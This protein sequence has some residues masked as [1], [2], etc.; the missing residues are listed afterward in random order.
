MLQFHCFTFNAFSEN[1]Y[2]V[3][4]E[5]KKA[6]LI[7][8]GC[9]DKDEQKTLVDYVEKK[10]LSVVAVYNTHCHID[11]VLGNDF[12]KNHFKVPI[13]VPEKELPQLRAVKLYAPMY[14]FGKY[15][16]AEPDGFVPETGFV[17]FGNSAMKILFVPG[18]A[19]GHVVFYAEKEEFCI[20][21]D[22]LFRESIG[23]TDLPGGNHEQLLKNIKEVMYKL[24]DS[25]LICSG[26]GQ[27]TTIGHE[28]KYNPF[29]R[30]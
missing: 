5:T 20:S 14:G 24:P 30:A 3:F 23:R 25:V 29:V 10:E 21:G 15:R 19:P 1:T 11:H 27:T 6:V 4:D 7:D 17:S 16:E 18:H 12:C 22:V 2:I 28:K 9:Y 8:P 13:Y 26:H